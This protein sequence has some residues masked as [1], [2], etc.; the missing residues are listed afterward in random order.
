MKMKGLNNMSNEPLVQGAFFASNLY[1]FHDFHTG[2]GGF[3]ADRELQNFAEKP[4]SLIPL[5][6]VK[7]IYPE[8]IKYIFRWVGDSYEYE[9]IAKY[10]KVWK[11]WY[12]SGASSARLVAPRSL[13]QMNPLGL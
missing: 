4:D 11:K 5:S 7:E 8:G 3:A 1:A 12:L 9:E 13:D 10:L 6:V 2:V